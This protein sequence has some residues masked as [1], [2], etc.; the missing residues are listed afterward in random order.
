MSNESIPIPSDVLL[1]LAE[2]AGGRRGLSQAIVRIGKGARAKYDVLTV[3]EIE[4]RRAAGETIETIIPVNA[5]HRTAARAKRERETVVTLRVPGAK[6]RKW[7]AAEVDALFLTEAAVE[8]FVLPYYAR[9]LPPKEY[10]ALVARYYAKESPPWALV[11]YPG[12]Q[13]DFVEGDE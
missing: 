1:R 13:Y 3:P 7:T 9:T 10:A 11:H 5:A 2:K 6:P 4:A 8:K 12:S